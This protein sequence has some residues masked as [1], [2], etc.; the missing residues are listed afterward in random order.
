MDNYPPSGERVTGVTP[1]HALAPCFNVDLWKNLTGLRGESE[2]IM[3]TNLPGLRGESEP[4]MWTS[5]PGLR[6]ESEP[7]R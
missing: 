5:L 4:G 6:G 1:D 2:P 7:G 3:W